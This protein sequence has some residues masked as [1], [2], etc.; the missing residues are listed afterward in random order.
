MVK[1]GITTVRG[2][3]A[4]SLCHVSGDRRQGAEHRQADALHGP[5]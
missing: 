1:A 3:Q 4:W 2:R 5:P